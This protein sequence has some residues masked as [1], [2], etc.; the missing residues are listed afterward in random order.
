MMRNPYTC[1]VR[2]NRTEIAQYL[3]E[4]GFTS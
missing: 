1:A 3:A 2:Y 4:N